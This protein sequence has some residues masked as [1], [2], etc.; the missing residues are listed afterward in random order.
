ML[1]REPE[2]LPGMTL[3]LRMQNNV[4]G[5]EQRWYRVWKDC[6]KPRSGHVIHCYRL[7]K[8]QFS[9]HVEK[10]AAE[11]LENQSNEFQRNPRKPWKVY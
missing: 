6:N 5:I 9:L 2:N 8:K 11:A 1:R 3:I 7:A 10:T 4:C